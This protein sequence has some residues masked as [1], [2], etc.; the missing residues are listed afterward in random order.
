MSFKQLL[1]GILVGVTSC[2]LFP[3]APAV[4]SDKDEAKTEKV[5]RVPDGK[6]KVQKPIRT[7]SPWDT[8]PI[9]PV[10]SRPTLAVVRAAHDLPRPH[11]REPGNCCGFLS[12]AHRETVQPP[13]Q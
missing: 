10:G 3:F 11:G 7:P 13:A 1:V 12:G 4:A 6:E 9:V 5:E 2:L 8:R